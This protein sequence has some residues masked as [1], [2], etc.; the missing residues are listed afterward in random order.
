MPN[1]YW[2]VNGLH[3]ID[4]EVPSSQDIEICESKNNC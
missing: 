4:T 2:N 1:F 3:D